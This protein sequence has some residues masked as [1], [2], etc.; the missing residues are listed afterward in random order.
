M[1]FIFARELIVEFKRRIYLTINSMLSVLIPTSHLTFMEVNSFFVESA[2]NRHLVAADDFDRPSF[3][4][5]SLYISC[6][7]SLKSSQRKAE[8]AAIDCEQ[9][10]LTDECAKYCAAFKALLSDKRLQGELLE[11]A[12]LPPT[13]FLQVMVIY[14]Y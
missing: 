12:I 2:N 11:H 14:Q 5:N 9:S 10:S 8:A 4:S 3:T 13:L 7:E 6:Q 1:T